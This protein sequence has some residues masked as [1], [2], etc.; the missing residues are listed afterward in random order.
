MSELILS[1]TNNPFKRSI[2]DLLLLILCKSFLTILFNTT[3]AETIQ[4]FVDNIDMTNEGDEL[5]ELVYYCDAEKKRA[6]ERILVDCKN[7]RNTLEKLYNEFAVV[8]KELNSD[9]CNGKVPQ[10]SFNDLKTITEDTAKQEGWYSNCLLNNPDLLYRVCTTHL[11]GYTDPNAIILR[12]GNPD[13]TTEMVNNFLTRCPEPKI[14]P[15]A[16]EEICYLYCLRFGISEIVRT[17]F[18]KESQVNEI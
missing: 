3:T 6:I 12:T 9:V 14:T 17:V 5:M 7:G 11:Q 10:T 8:R 15:K 4:N 13:I 18:L 2:K 1:I 16:R